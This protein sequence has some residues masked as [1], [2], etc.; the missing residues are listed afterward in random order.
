MAAS[1]ASARRVAVMALSSSFMPTPP[2]A[3]AGLRGPEGMALHGPGAD[4]Q[5]GGDLLLGQVEE[6]AQHDDLALPLRQLA[7]RDR[8]LRAATVADAFALGR[9]RGP[10]VR[11]HEGAG[12]DAPTDP[13]PGAVDDGPVEVGD[14]SARVAE[15]VPV[16]VERLERV[17]HDLLRRPVVVDQQRGQA[18]EASVVREE[19]R[20]DRPSRRGGELAD[21][22]DGVDVPHGEP[23]SWCGCQ[24]LV[25]RA[26]QRLTLTT[27]NFE[28]CRTTRARRSPVG[29][30]PRR[31]GSR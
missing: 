9:L 15:P 14:R 18:D 20:G 4:T 24:G 28:G 10:G 31:T 7:D 16:A 21:S 27:R 13:G 5:P 17:L 23:P 30:G 2:S 1:W 26:P 29:P 19:Q 25:A 3:S 12:R 8:Q 22:G 6:V 11:E